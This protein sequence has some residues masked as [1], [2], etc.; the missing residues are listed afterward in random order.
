[1]DPEAPRRLAQPGAGPSG[2]TNL[3][4]ARASAWLSGAGGALILF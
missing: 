2:A 4:S 3:E 1:M